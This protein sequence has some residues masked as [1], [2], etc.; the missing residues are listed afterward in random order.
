MIVNSSGVKDSWN[1]FYPFGLQMDLRNGSTSADARYKFTG[2]ERDIETGYDWFNVRGYDSRIGRFLGIDPH[3]LRY[4]NLSPYV[5]CGNNPIGFIDPTGM[6]ST[7]SKS[8]NGSQTSNWQF[9]FDGKIKYFT[10]NSSGSSTPAVSTSVSTSVSKGSNSSPT[11][12]DLLKSFILTAA[13]VVEKA[14]EIHETAEVATALEGESSLLLES[15][16]F[17][18]SA[19][20]IVAPFA[21]YYEYKTGEISK[22][23]AWYTGATPAVAWGVAAVSTATAGAAVGTALVGG[24]VGYDGLNAAA[25]CLN[26]AAVGF[27]YQAV[28]PLIPGGY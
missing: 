13:K 26:D 21:A 5:Y 25:K 17:L 7:G 3:S 6:D 19:A 23:E 1:D 11:T 16:N 8:Q 4:P 20:A 28:S 14:N 10:T 9:G 2:K 27:Y 24:K 15:T 12:K 18:G 22:G